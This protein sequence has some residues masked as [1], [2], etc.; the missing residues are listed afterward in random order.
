[1]TADQ[2][3][4]NRSGRLL[5]TLRLARQDEACGPDVLPLLFCIDQKVGLR[6]GRRYL[7][8]CGGR[9]QC[10][11]SSRPGLGCLEASRWHGG[12]HIALALR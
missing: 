7:A 1:M 12:A 8:D 5:I 6:A 10:Y 4:A 2:T 9:G 11:D 3:V